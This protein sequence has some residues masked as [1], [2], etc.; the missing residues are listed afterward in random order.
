[1]SGAQATV[2]ENMKDFFKKEGIE[3]QETIHRT[4]RLAGYICGEERLSSQE[5]KRWK[6]LKVMDEEDRVRMK[7]TGD[8][9]E[10]LM[11]AMVW[12]GKLSKA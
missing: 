1:M 8:G 2:Y 5:K 10:W 4:A 6:E 7:D 9:I 3:N 11:I 12:E